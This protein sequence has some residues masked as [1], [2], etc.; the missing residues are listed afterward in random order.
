MIIKILGSGCKRC[1]ALA[2]KLRLRA[3]AA[4][5]R[6]H[7]RDEPHPIELRAIVRQ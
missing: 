1:V 6:Q 5:V 3:C 2:E 4:Q 7:A